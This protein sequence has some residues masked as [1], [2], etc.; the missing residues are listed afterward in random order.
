MKK[1]KKLKIVLC[2][3]ALATLNFSCIVD[4]STG[5]DNL[6][7]FGESNYLVGFTKSV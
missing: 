2:A 7:A 5:E 6:N 3:V 1:M 4:D